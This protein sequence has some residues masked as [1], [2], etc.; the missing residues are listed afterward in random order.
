[1]DRRPVV[2]RSLWLAG[3][4]AVG[5]WLVASAI[6]RF[7]FGVD[8]INEALIPLRPEGL[9]MRV[10]RMIMIV[11]F[12]VYA[13]MI[14]GRLQS[15]RDKLRDSEKKY[16]DLFE[17]ANDAILIVDPSTHRFLEVNQVA[18]DL[19]GYSREEF[20]RMTIEDL[21]TPETGAHNDEA[22]RELFA[23][24]KVI[25]QREHR[26]K[27]G[28]S[29]PVE[30]SCRLSE[31][32][33]RQV[34]Q[35]YV[36]DMTE[37]K[38]SEAAL[39]GA[40]Q[41]LRT[42]VNNA[43]IAIFAT[44]SQ[45]VFTLSEGKGLQRAGLKP[46][47]NVGTSA[48]D[49]FT[50]LNIVGETGVAVAGE[51]VLCR[52]LAGETMT[53][54][55]EQRGS[56]FENR[57]VPLRDANER[58]IGLAGVSSDITER[59][60][61]EQALKAQY[62]TLK[63]ILESTDNLI[64]SLDRDCRYTSFNTAHDASMRAI[65]GAEIQIGQSILDY[66]TVAEDREIA[67]KALDRALAGER[68]TVEEWSGEEGRSRR[69]FE[70]SHSPILGE[71]G[72]ASGVAVF[73][74]NVTDRKRIEEQMRRSEADLKQAQRFAHVGGWRWDIKTNVLNWSDEM[75]HLYGIDRETFSGSLL[76]VA[77]RA[78]H[79][80][81][82][83]KVEKAALSTAR[84]G[85]LLAVEYRVIWPDHSIHVLRS[86]AGELRF[87][88][89]GSPSLAS[90]IVQD[91]T[92]RKLAEEKLRESER[93][94]NETQEI[95]RVGG[96]EYD[97]RTGRATWT[98]EAY[99]IYGVGEDYDPSDITKAIGFYAD[100]DRK[101]IE[102][103]FANAVDGGQPYDLELQF[104]AGDGSKK[105]VRTMGRP[106]IE[107]GKTARVV[108]NIADITERKRAEE[109]LRQSESRLL[110]AQ[111]IGGVGNWDWDLQANEL[112]WS[113]QN[114]LIFGIPRDVKPSVENFLA[115]VDPVDLGFV[116]KSM[117]AA[118]SGSP[119]DIDM[120]IIRH[121]GSR[122]IVNAQGEVTFDAAG[123]AIRMFG[124]VQD[125][126]ERKHTEEQL[127]RAQ[128]L[129]LAGRIAGQV[130]HDFNNLLSP[131]VAYPELLKLE[132]PED[133]PG[134]KLCDSMIR[135]ARQ[136]ADINDDLLALSRRGQFKQE[137]TELGPLVYQAVGQLSPLPA[138]LALVI[139]L[140][141]DLLPVNGSGAQLLRVIHNLISNAR[142]AMRDVGTLRLKGETV[143]VDTP[144]HGLDVIA[145]GEYVRLQVADSGSGIPL[146]VRES[147]FE[148]FFTTKRADRRRG[149]GLG[150]SVVQS[151]VHDHNGYLDLETAAGIG[152]TF[153]VYLPVSRGALRKDQPQKIEA[154]SG[155]I[156][157]VDD[158]ELQHEVAGRMLRTLGYDVG[159]VSGGQEA[160]DY[161]RERPVDLVLLDMIMPGG[162]DGLDTYR[163]IL[164]VRPGQKA[165]LV[166]GYADSERVRRLQDLGAGAFLRKP[167]RLQTL[168]EAIRDELERG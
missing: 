60:L 120:R 132:L 16:H 14:I 78:I 37:R 124:T 4:L 30:V 155:S 80:D 122:G 147:I 128:R 104:I 121:D 118:L 52:V 20:L 166:S 38:R 114:Y 98:G 69:Y 48:L 79:P 41:L 33:G 74:Q 140:A 43:P 148:P 107:G 130:A 137:P 162:M 7:L 53:G 111:R 123:K 76:D 165:I 144:V 90:G 100:G 154:G 146:E 115:T 56:Y 99:R 73:A 131:L 93:L 57:L 21:D 164:E 17:F 77:E 138:T 70:V 39:R 135:A 151:I 67:R 75:F 95:S 51:V 13:R 113:D 82:R 125:V 24:G 22:L 26:R 92:E 145:V 2:D 152:T 110:D 72:S 9:Y 167:A 109:A 149:S 35:S 161:L 127:L 157:I 143:Y 58:V 91:I 45:G 32:D 49:V 11:G 116:K 6:D 153:S 117:E 65:Y 168:A 40:E 42:V 106:L 85:N 83:S 156:L 15:A 96:W 97:A 19:L 36:R 46:G 23:T 61:A 18:S 44:D 3:G 160:V 5:F 163:K 101:T 12:V 1:M 62:S 129:D 10:L 64:F 54:I 119:Y 103:A 139:D 28:T 31:Y 88:K 134:V 136:I 47:E 81:D 8:T 86:E 89:E 25:A 94:L 68:H 87:D 102:Q 55:T 71:D 50:S 63:G 150:L 112:Y 29:I 142:E 141:A 105:W 84:D 133:H 59:R 108:G 126:T 34:L 66:M 158:D 27:D 159:A